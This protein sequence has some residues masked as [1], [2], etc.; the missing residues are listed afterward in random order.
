MQPAKKIDE[1]KPADLPQKQVSMDA[2]DQ[3]R[4]GRARAGGSG[5]DD[6]DDLN[7]LEV[8]R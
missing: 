6:D 4:G 7:E 8:Q 3:V 1:A 5:S 2:A